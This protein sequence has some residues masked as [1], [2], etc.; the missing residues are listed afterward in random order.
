MTEG[1]NPSSEE[2]RE[3]GQKRFRKEFPSG[4]MEL[5]RFETLVLVLDALLESPSSREFTTR[6]LANKAGPSKRSVESRISALVELGVVTRHIEG[7]EK[8]RY[9][10]NEGNPI[11]QRLYDLNTTVQR[12][13]EGDLPKT[14]DGAPPAENSNTP[15]E[16]NDSKYNYP[17]GS[18]LKKIKGGNSESTP[19][20]SGF[21]A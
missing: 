16:N 15:G 9:S 20:H 3:M 5:T 11:V 10:I 2:I 18:G 17:S 6:E 21:R 4:W 14:I 7:R 1:E 12:V 13:E 19:N 8:P